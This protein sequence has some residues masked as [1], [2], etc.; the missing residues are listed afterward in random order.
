M[1]NE[2][3]DPERAALAECEGIIERHKRTFVEV[4][5]ALRTIR[6]QRLYR[7]TH[8]TFEDYC[9][10]RW[11]LGRSRSHQLVAA[12]NVLDNLSTAVDMPNS[13]WQIRPLASL[14]PDQQ[15]A[16]WNTAVRTSTTGV[17]TGP[18]VAAVVREMKPAPTPAEIEAQQRAREA[19]RRLAEMMDERR[20]EEMRRYSIFRRLIEATQLIAEF[21]ME[22]ADA[23]DGI[24]NAGG[25]DFMDHLKRAVICLTRLEKEHPNEL[26]RPNIVIVRR[27]EGDSA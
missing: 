6:D 25:K 2:L 12:V 17:P 16:A 9:R 7:A 15:Q 21:H 10:E 1:T 11:A 27:K 18:E 22:S 24:W 4:G 23:W 5:N 8:A 20:T 3:L 13:E 26:K 19:E 14:P